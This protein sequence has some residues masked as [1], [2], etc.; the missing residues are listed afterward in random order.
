MEGLLNNKEEEFKALQSQISEQVAS[1]S[2][3]K[4]GLLRGQASCYN[5][6]ATSLTDSVLIVGRPA[7]T[8]GGSSAGGQAPGGRADLPA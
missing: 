8:S 5:Q 6:P 4:V 2:T 7:P 3:E 1:F